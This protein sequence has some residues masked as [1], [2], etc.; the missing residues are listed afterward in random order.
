MNKWGG[1]IPTLTGDLFI[2]DIKSI[3]WGGGYEC[4]S[5]KGNSYWCKKI[6]ISDDSSPEEV[7][8]QIGDPHRQNNMI[9]FPVIIKSS[10][11]IHNVET[12][13]VCY[14]GV[15]S[16]WR[17]GLFLVNGSTA[18][19][20]STLDHSFSLL[21][22]TAVKDIYHQHTHHE[23]STREL[24]S[25]IR[26]NTKLE[27]VRGLMNQYKEK[28]GIYHYLYRKYVGQRSVVTYALDTVKGILK[29]LRLTERE[30]RPG[31]QSW[32]SFTASL[33][34]QAQGEMLYS[35]M[36]LKVL[37]DYLPEDERKELTQVFALACD[38]FAI[39]RREITE[40]YQDYS[41]KILILLTSILAIL[42]IAYSLP[43]PASLSIFILLMVYVLA[44]PFRFYMKN[45][46]LP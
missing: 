45:R 13:Y 28:I 42:G 32:S 12:A 43:W 20:L 4:K 46:N 1:W 41:N 6:R 22:Y 3:L 29:S 14:Q 16:I 44:V 34:M 9:T 10:N 5:T 15:C 35:R 33:I 25:L 8:F 27:I 19:G 40:V 7:L 37:G 18:K 26:T 11:K 17:N 31:V 24:L 2:T 30:R 36:A 39:V 38:S 21:I 23:D